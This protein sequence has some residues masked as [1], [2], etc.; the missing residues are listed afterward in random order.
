MIGLLNGCRCSNLSNLTL[1][2]L[3]NA[4]PDLVLPHA[5]VSGIKDMD[6]VTHLTHYILILTNEYTV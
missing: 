1:K 4:V 5:M 2:D 3:E 6:N